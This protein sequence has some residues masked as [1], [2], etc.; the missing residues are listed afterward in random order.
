M[1]GTEIREAFLEYFERNGH[2][3][4]RSSSARSGQTTRR[5]SSPTPAWCSSRACSWAR[6]A[7]TTCAPPPARSA[8]GPAASTTTSRT[9][10]RTARHHT[11]FEMLGNFSFGDYFKAD[12]IRFAWEFLTKELG[13]DA[14]P[15]DRHGLHGRRRGVRA[16][17][18]GRRA[19]RRAHPAP[20]REGQLL[21][22][23]RHRPVRPVLGGPLPPGRPPAVRRGGGGAAVPGPGLRVRPL[24]GDLEPRVHAVQPRRQRRA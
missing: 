7:A 8:C 14:E 19:G 5:C 23:G 10:G 11:F 24:A 21:G 4:V 18:E 15:A 6:S 17:E 1:T 20:G 13:I 3:R 22:D 9:S 16:L 2:T 12:A